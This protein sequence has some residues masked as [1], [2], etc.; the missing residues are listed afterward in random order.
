[1]FGLLLAFNAGAVNAGGVLVVHMYT[2]HMTGFAS[3][4]ADGAV[5]GNAEL[6]LGAL[7]ALLAFVVGAATASVIVHW[8]LKHHLSSAFAIPLMLEAA[9]LLVFGLLGA[10]TLTW[11]TLFAVP[12]TVLLLSFIMGLQNGLSSTMSH[13][14]LRTTH[15]TGHVTDLGLELGRLVYRNQRKTPAT[16][17]VL[18]NRAALKFHGGLLAMFV[19]G[20]MVGAAGFKYIGFVWVVPLAALL[21][22]L[23]LPPFRRDLRRSDFLRQRLGTMGGRFRRPRPTAA[24]ASPGE[25]PAQA[26]AQ[27]TK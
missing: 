19:V 13:G 10:V 17:R 14:R 15:M 2:S 20:G 4:V 26:E 11:P 22:A 5:L 8:G 3:Q 7:G 12:L 24:A 16:E 23:S 18:A 6:L 25:A 21:L 9:L 27:Q 1:M